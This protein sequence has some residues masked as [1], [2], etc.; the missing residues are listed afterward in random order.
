MVM[1]NARDISLPTPTSQTDALWMREIAKIVD[2]QGDE[3]EQL[4]RLVQALSGGR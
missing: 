4:K 1:K 3:I 2:S